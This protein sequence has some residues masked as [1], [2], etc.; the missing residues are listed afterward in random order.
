MLTLAFDTATDV[1]TSAL[2]WDGEVL[3]ELRSRPVSVLEDVD[4]LVRPRRSPSRRSSKAS[5]SAPGPGAS[6]GCAWVSP[7]RAR[8]RSRSTCRVAGVSTLAALG[9]GAPGAL[10][11]IDARRGEVFVLT[12]SR[13]SPP[14]EVDVAAGCASG[15]EP[16]ATASRLEEHGAEVPPDDDDGTFRRRASTCSSPAS[17]APPTRSSRST[18][19]SPTRSRRARDHPDAAA[20]RPARDRARSSASR[21]RRRGRG[22]CSRAS[23]RR[24]RRSA[25]VRSRTTGELVGYL[26]VSRYVD[27]WHVMNIAVDPEHRRRGASRRRCCERLFELTT[28]TDAA[29]TRSRCAC[30]TRRDQP[31]RGARLPAP[32]NPPRLLHRQ[33]RGRA[34]HVAGPCS[35]ASPTSR[36]MR[37]VARTSRR[38]APLGRC[39][40]TSRHLGRGP[41]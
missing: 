2:V 12:A 18:C 10:P 23:S 31:L 37:C 38:P 9:A 4:A 5:S 40:E 21:T 33:P 25:S 20:P 14:E 1:A 29:A 22:R 11:V 3:G 34:D 19:A 36:L 32:R 13:A 16:S 27:A 26:I 6:P 7:P 8:S 35:L 39:R 15:T 30:R 17:S 28:A 41:R 24:R